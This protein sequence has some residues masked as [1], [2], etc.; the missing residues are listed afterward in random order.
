MG[1]NQGGNGPGLSQALK[2]QLRISLP[3]FSQLPHMDCLKWATVGE[4]TPWELTSITNQGIFS[5]ES[6]VEHY[7]LGGWCL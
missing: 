1:V 5:G 2:R 6:I 3:R 7:T 4:L